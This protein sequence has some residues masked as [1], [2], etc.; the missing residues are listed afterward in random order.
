[1]KRIAAVL[2]LAGTSVLGFV[3]APAANAADCPDG[4]IV[5]AHVHGNLNGTPVDQDVCLPPA[6]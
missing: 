5:Q 2:T 6:G 3:A 4:T 1:M